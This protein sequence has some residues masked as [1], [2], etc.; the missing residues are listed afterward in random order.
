[1]ERVA[2][3]LGCSVSKISRIET[4]RIGVSARDLGDLLKLYGVAG[5]RWDALL[6]LAQA[7]RQ[8]D[9]WQQAYRDLPVTA[10][11]G[12]EAEAISLREYSMALVPGLLQ[13]R[14]YATAVL[15]G[16]RVD[17]STKEIVRRV[18]LRMARQAILTKEDARSCGWW[19]MRQ[20]CAARSAVAKSC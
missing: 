3:T 11:I 2:E 16:I 6:F 15:T 8:K 17:L 19:S 20:F 13:T 5:E 4:A 7:A 12:L 14:D 10:L 9:W 18:E 1:M